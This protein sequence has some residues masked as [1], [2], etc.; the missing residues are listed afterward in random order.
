[1][2]CTW[3]FLY[4]GFNLLNISKTATLDFLCVCVWEYFC[5]FPSTLALKCLQ[6]PAYI[7]Q[8][9][10]RFT[11]LRK[12]LQLLCFL[13]LERVSLLCEF[14]TPYFCFWT[15]PEQHCITHSSKQQLFTLFCSWVQTQ[16][17]LSSLFNVTFSQ[18]Q[19]FSDWLYLVH[20][21]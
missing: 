5:S 1:M 13:Q 2:K 6:P 17:I 10:K 9:S 20:Q 14:T 11:Q 8:F 15:A 7:F 12:C 3:F 4:L 18:S 21:V 16:C 19:L